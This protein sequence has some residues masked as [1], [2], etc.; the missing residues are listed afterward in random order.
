MFTL[1]TETFTKN[2]VFVFKKSLKIP[3]DQSESLQKDQQ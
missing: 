1:C 2:H 3:K